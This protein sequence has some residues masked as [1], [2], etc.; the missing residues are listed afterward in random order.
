DVQGGLQL[1]V[2]L[3]VERAA[4]LILLHVVPLR[5][6]DGEAMLYSGAALTEGDP[7]RLLGELVPADL[8]VP[9]RCVVEVGDPEEQIAAFARRERVGLL[10][11]EARRRSLL[12]RALGRR[13][14]VQSIYQ[15]DCHVDT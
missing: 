7:E 14:V 13:L 1:A 12:R 6:S 15:G 5:A 4:P 8:S 2:R 10:V 9:Y 11:L 3:A